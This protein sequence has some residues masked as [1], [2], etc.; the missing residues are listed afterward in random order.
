MGWGLEEGQDLPSGWEA[1][2]RQ[3]WP[4]GTSAR[5]LGCSGHRSRQ[6]QGLSRGSR[7]V[8]AQGV[9]WAEAS[10][11]AQVNHIRLPQNRARQGKVGGWKPGE[12]GTCE[13]KAGPPLGASPLLSHPT[14]EIWALAG[15]LKGLPSP[16]SAITDALSASC[17]VWTLP[18]PPG[19]AARAPRVVPMVRAQ[20]GRPGRAQVW[21]G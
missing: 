21:V 19:G 8:Q 12:R 16:F 14:D 11:P 13:G 9:L 18:H 3:E 10:L 2:H 17:R 6:V 7:G 20:L 1:G 4:P 5:A 15:G